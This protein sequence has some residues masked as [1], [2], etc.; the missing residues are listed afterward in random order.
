MDVLRDSV[1]ETSNL[2]HIRHLYPLCGW[3]SM[4]LERACHSCSGLTLSAKRVGYCGT[5]L[6]S[7]SL[8]REAETDP[9]MEAFESRSNLA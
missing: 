5:G 2:V 3:S 7:H 1:M 4:Q 8:D 6:D 9:L